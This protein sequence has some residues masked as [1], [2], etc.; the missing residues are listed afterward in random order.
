MIVVRPYLEEHVPAV[1]AFNR[2]L[3]D[4]GAPPEFTFPASPVPRWLPKLAGRVVY[5]EFFLALEE[6]VVRGAY[7]L[8]TQPFAF[9][10]DMQSVGYYH[11]PFSEGIVDRAYST[12]GLQLLRDALRRQPHLFALGMSGYDRP[13]PRMLVALKWFHGL[14]P[15][16]FKVV[17]PMRFLRGMRG[18]RQT[19]LRRIAMDLAAFTGTGAIG[20][21]S[22]QAWRAQRGRRRGISSEV[23][24]TFGPWADELWRD[25]HRDYGMVGLRDTTTLNVLFAPDNPRFRR[26]RVTEHGRTI[27]WAVLGER[28]QK[29]HPQSGDLR[30]GVLLD[31]WARPAHAQAVVNEAAAALAATGVDLMT[32]NQSHAAWSQ[33]LEQ[34]G[35]LM[36]PSNFIF[37]MP[38]NIGVATS[39]LTRADG[40]G[41]Y[42]YL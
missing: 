8:K 37:A 3:R 15:F 2:R 18:L 12:V 36:G 34:A 1:S 31:A 27:G 10:G 24:D 33:A 26:L 6:G 14:V 42:Q 17:K 38:K 23:V 28:N 5:N 29:D 19:P 7:A 11:H 21:H 4:G 25:C 13:L 20:L 39:H 16:Y 30:V 35:F 41:L 22:L 32:S 40:D 9:A